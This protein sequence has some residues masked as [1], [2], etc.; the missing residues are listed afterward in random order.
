VRSLAKEIAGG[1][2]LALLGLRAGK[3]QLIFARAEGLTVDC[4][5]LLREA[6]APFGGRGGGQAT[7]AQGG[8]PDATKLEAALEAAV[9][10]VRAS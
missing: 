9:E 4:G 2:C 5:A 8:V 3:A 10:R 7:L 1:G 6:L